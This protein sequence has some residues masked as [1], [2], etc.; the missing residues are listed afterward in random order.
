M[1]DSMEKISN[2]DI[3]NLTINLTMKCNMHCAYC[4]VYSQEIPEHIKQKDITLDEINLVLE[5]YASL[6]HD[7]NGVKVLDI[8][9]HGGE[10][11]IRGKKFFN[12]LINMQKIL[13]DEKQI[14]VRN[15]LQSNGTLID[16]EWAEFFYRYNFSL[17]ISLDGP[18]EYHS[19]NRYYANKNSVVRHDFFQ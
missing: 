15:R 17:G 7:D 3:D 11:L 13:F 6:P 10:P 5:Q 19:I 9:W 1:L 8:T 12:E 18:E 16:D 4:Y 2:L 14:L